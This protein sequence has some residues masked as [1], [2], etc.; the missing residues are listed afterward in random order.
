MPILENCVTLKSR[1]WRTPRRRSA[2]ICSSQVPECKLIMAHAGSQPF[3]HGDWNR[4]IMA[5]KRFENLYLDTASSTIDA[6]FLET[7]VAALGARR[8]IFGTDTP[9]LD[10]WPQLTKIRETRLSPA[11][12]DLIHG[13]QH[14]APD[15]GGGVIFDINAFIGKWPYWP[16]R[17]TRA[18]EVA[19]ELAGWRIDRAAICSTRSIFV[20]WDDGN[21]EVAQAGAAAS[22]A[23]RPFR[24]PRDPGTQPRAAR[25]GLRFR[26]LC[27][28]RVPRRPTLS[29]ASQLSS[30]VRAVCRPD[31]GRSRRARLA[32]AASP[33]HR[34]ELGPCRCSTWR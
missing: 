27:R 19:Q 22:G 29:A 1:S 28:A 21:C 23:F 2:S 24:L 17:S 11:D 7:C 4:A 9:L 8:M 20:H 18:A 13:R 32:R 5:A 31:S 34:D 16:V 25:T 6:G 33:A 14:S 12:L 26:G 3:A 15:G 30:T 10:P